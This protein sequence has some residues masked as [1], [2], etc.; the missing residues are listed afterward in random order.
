M[1]RGDIELLATRLASH[2]IVDA[3]HVVAQLG[4]ERPV[5]FVST[6]RDTIFSRAN[7]PTHL[8]VVGAPAPWTSQP[9]GSHFV[10]IVEE[11]AFVERHRLII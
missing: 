9:V 8:V 6:W 10:P 1:L 11:I 5:S 4:K 2:R 7:D 3:D